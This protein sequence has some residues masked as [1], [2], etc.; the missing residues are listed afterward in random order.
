MCL[1]PPK[2][3]PYVPIALWY[4]MFWQGSISNLLLSK[5]A[6]S[7]F[8]DFEQKIEPVISQVPKVQLSSTVSKIKMVRIA[9][10]DGLP[11]G[12]DIKKTVPPNGEELEEFIEFCL[13]KKKD[14]DG[15]DLQFGEEWT[16]L[17]PEMFQY[18]DIVY[19]S[20]ECHWV[21]VKKERQKILAMK[22]KTYTGDDLV[23]A[24]GTAARGWRECVIRIASR[25]TIPSAVYRDW[26]AAIEK[27]KAGE[28]FP[29][30]LRSDTDEPSS[31]QSRPG[32]RG[33]GKSKAHSISPESE[34]AQSSG[35]SAFVPSSSAPAAA[36]GTAAAEV[37][38]YGKRNMYVSVGEMGNMTRGAM[39]TPPPPP[40][41][42]PT[43]TRTRRTIRFPRMRTPASPLRH[44]HW[45]SHS[46]TCSAR[47][48]LGG[49]ASSSSSWPDGAR[50]MTK[51]MR[52]FTLTILLLAPCYVLEKRWEARRSGRTPPWRARSCQALVQLL[53]V[54]RG[55]CAVAAIDQYGCEE[56]RGRTGAPR[57]HRPGGQGVRSRS[58]SPIPRRLNQR[59]TQSRRGGKE[60]RHAVYVVV[61]R[62]RGAEAR[63]AGGEYWARRRHSKSETKRNETHLKMAVGRT[64]AGDDRINRSQRR[65]TSPTSI[66][67]SS[68]VA[69]ISAVV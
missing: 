11:Y 9:R 12:V 13:S 23:Q 40:P 61:F 21:L 34:E 49:G 57:R 59:P 60:G 51:G 69:A 67:H 15:A 28:R 14:K 30:E 41:P 52:A 37:L 38:S 62:V 68:N 63:A 32:R 35:E 16:I 47:G 46:D 48:A 58:V 10:V 4:Q 36:I 18:L 64:E 6:G 65:M 2:E 50:S 7:L 39:Q 66:L 29:S 3:F 5:P 43:R 1:P 24:K 31:K 54:H 27:A 42:P 56:K 44:T 22:R 45:H 20:E 17:L 25:H 19:G 53:R 55:P 33:K 8:K 26:P